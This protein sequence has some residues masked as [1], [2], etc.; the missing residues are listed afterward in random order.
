MVDFIVSIFS[1]VI[2]LREIK[3]CSVTS[4]GSRFC[5]FSNSPSGRYSAWSAREWPEN[6]YV[7]ASTSVGPP[8]L[9]ARST[10]S[11]IPLRTA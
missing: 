5:H 8:P 9:R 7:F 1:C 4:S 2:N 6:R 3:S 11:P 10:A